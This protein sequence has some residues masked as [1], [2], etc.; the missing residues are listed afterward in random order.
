MADNKYPNMRQLLNIVETVE[1]S[2]K[3]QIAAVAQLI[4]DRTE[5]ADSESKLSTK[6][7]LMLL[8]NLG[9]P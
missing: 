6:A 1:D 9:I 5:D 8:N 4:A 2:Q 7:F 3:E